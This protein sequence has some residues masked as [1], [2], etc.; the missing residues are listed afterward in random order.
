MTGEERRLGILPVFPDYQIEPQRFMSCLPVKITQ[1][2][3]LLSPL[4]PDRML[5]FPI[6]K[7]TLPTVNEQ[8][9]SVLNPE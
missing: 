6:I 3:S 7:S 9:L 1:S 5:I 8:I 4:L 2:L